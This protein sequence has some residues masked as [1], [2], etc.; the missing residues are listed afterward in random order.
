M[1]EIIIN[2][3]NAQT[4]TNLSNP[5]SV[6]SIADLVGFIL[7]I[8][9][10]IGWALA[11][12]FLAYGFIQYI[13]SKGEKNA[14]EEAQKTITFAIIGGI[15]LLLLGAVRSMLEGILGAGVLPEGYVPTT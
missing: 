1:K 6:T 4:A 14:T 3:V 13:T 15:G 12:G 5:L 10:G 7:N 9:T 8:I 11:F 2:K